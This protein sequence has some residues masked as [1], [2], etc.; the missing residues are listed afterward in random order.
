MVRISPSVKI[1]SAGS[2]GTGA[3]VA[4]EG[5]DCVGSTVDVFVDTLGSEGDSMLLQ[6]VNKMRKKAVNAR[7]ILF[8]VSPIPV[9]VRPRN[10]TALT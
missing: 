2:T 6:P 1:T 10:F 3:D 7:G 8:I 9:N 4:V 5:G